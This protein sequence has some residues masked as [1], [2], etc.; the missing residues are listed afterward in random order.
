MPWEDIKLNDGRKIPGISFGTSRH[1]GDTVS[2]VDEA[3]HA[4]FNSLDTAQ[5]YKSENAV[6]Q[7]IKE[8]GI[9]RK[10]LWITTKWSGLKNAKESIKDS[11]NHLG[12]NHVDLYLI[13]F[14]AVAKDDI[15]G[16]WAHLEEFKKLGYTKSIGV[17]NFEISHLKELLHHAKIK[18]SVNQIPFHPNILAKQEPLIKYLQ[19]NEIAIE[20]YSPLA[21][22]WQDGAGA[23]VLK[24]VKS[25]ASKYNVPEERIL[26][27]WTRSKG[28]IPVTSSSTK[29]RIESFIAAGDLT[30]SDE[31]IKSI[32]KAGYKAFLLTELKK[33]LINGV[34]WFTVA[35]LVTYFAVRRYS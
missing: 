21:P 32:D 19:E 26:L 8:S 3:I 5:I 30:L 10:E 9:P 2:T 13:H 29:S 12:V 23:P 27:A 18:P 16:S 22:L 31:D 24:A 34:K 7:A 6:G 15:P 11:L 28:V 35:G 33:S 25:L 1:S 17:S 14:P 4:G 20:G